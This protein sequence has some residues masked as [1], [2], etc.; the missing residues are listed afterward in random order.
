V[1][2]Q[3][4]GNR[5]LAAEQG[6]QAADAGQTQDKPTLNFSRSGQGQPAPGFFS[7]LKR[8]V[9]RAKQTAMPGGQ[10]KAWL[11][12]NQAQLGVKQDEIEATGI[13]EYLD[14]RGKDKVTREEI[15][16]FVEN[17]GVRVEEVVKGGEDTKGTAWYIGYT[18]GPTIGSSYAT[19]EEAEADMADLFPGR[20]DVE[21]RQGTGDRAL[22]QNEATKF[23]KWQLPGGKNYKELLLTLPVKPTAQQEE[24]E[25]RRAALHE[26]LRTAPVARQQEILA[27]LDTLLPAMDRAEQTATAGQYQSGHY[28]EPNILAHVRINERTDTDGKRVLFVE[29][30]Q[31]DWGQQGE[32]KDLSHHQGPGKR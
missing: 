30:I 18:G 24:L 12:A 4:S 17:N 3:G 9:E 29:E 6:G 31:S 7:Q 20:N 16:A 19:Q 10:W 22:R 28:S 11:K 13:D 21:I 5:E 15:A 23:D 2:V 8:V 14:A 26:E 1:Q 32:T 27:E 25:T